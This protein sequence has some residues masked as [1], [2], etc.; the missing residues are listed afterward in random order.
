MNPLQIAVL[1]VLRSVSFGLQENIADRTPIDTGRAIS[2]WNVSA[3]EANPETTPALRANENEHAAKGA[4]TLSKGQAMTAMRG[5][6]QNVP[7]G[8]E[9]IVISNALPYIEDLEN[10]TSPQSKPGAMVAA[11]VQESEIEILI[12]QAITRLTVLK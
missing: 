4:S 10:G 9:V 12:D 8:A 1:D 6:R 5:S 3:T 7:I 11:S 2:S